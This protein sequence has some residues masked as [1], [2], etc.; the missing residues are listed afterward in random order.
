MPSKSCAGH[1]VRHNV[2]EMLQRNS[3]Y[4]YP[5]E[6]ARAAVTKYHRVAQ[7]TDLSGLESG[8]PRCQQVGFLLRPLSLIC[9]W[10]PSC[11]GFFLL[12]VH[13]WCLF[14]EANLFFYKDTVRLEYNPPQQP[15]FN[16]IAFVKG[17][18]SRYNDMLKASACGFGGT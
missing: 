15:H 14:I 6:P 17:P 13:P 8:R 18:L 5:Y 11:H 3:R 12:S 1:F 2:A 9:R 7:P 16:F 10:L 4:H